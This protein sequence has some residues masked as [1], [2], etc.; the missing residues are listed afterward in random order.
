VD[1]ER[2]TFDRGFSGRFSSNMGFK[3]DFDEYQAEELASDSHNMNSSLLRFKKDESPPPEI[4]VISLE[5]Q[6]ET[7][8][9]QLVECGHDSTNAPPFKLF[10]YKKEEK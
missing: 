8:S 10:Y 3:Y 7:E 1:N 2:E 9:L 5:E 6:D 4:P